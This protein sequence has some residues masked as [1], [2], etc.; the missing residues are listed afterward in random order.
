MPT[1]RKKRANLAGLVA[2]VALHRN[3][4][5]VEVAN[6]KLTDS[7]LVASALLDAFRDLTKPYPELT[8]DAGSV[9]AGAGIEVPDEEGIEDGADPISAKRKVVGFTAR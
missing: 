5:S 4:L 8:L 7:A 6:V 2:S 1:K 3:G 9:G